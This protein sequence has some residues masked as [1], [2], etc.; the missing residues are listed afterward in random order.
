MA[1]RLLS[2]SLCS[3]RSAHI[4]LQ[5]DRNQQLFCTLG[6]CSAHSAFSAESADGEVL[7]LSQPQLRVDMSLQLLS[8]GVLLPGAPDHEVACIGVLILVKAQACDWHGSENDKYYCSTATAHC[9][10]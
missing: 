9:E 4:V 8:C 2:A 7:S 6:I 3:T 10:H 5:P 1:R